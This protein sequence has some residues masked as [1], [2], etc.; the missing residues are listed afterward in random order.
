[1]GFHHDKVDPSRLAR[2]PYGAPDWFCTT[3]YLVDMDRHSPCFSIVPRSR[4]YDS[5]G[6]AKEGLGDSYYEQPVW[7]P[8][9]TCVVYDTAVYHTRLDPLMSRPGGGG[10]GGRRSLHQWWARGTQ[11]DAARP[12][13]AP[14][15]PI[16][17]IPPRL[18]MHEDPEVR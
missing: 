3:T 10:V 12:P 18:C 5:L 1:M 11:T 15:Q 16:C 17:K 7:G 9:G 4:V 13:S 6:A 14:L 2:S 8:A